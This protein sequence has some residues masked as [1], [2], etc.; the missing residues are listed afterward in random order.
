MQ[1]ITTMFIFIIWLTIWFGH[2][3]D[4]AL[5]WSLSCMYNSRIRA[6][7]D[8]LST[9]T[10]AVSFFCVH[11]I[12]C[13]HSNPKHVQAHMSMSCHTRLSQGKADDMGFYAVCLQ[14]LLYKEK[15]V[16]TT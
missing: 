9:E 16:L 13:N 12:V 3:I 6:F 11:W 14:M 7:L 8:E 5:N 1:L 2:P 15:K 10:C 4:V